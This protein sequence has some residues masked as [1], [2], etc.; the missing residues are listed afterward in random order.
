MVVPKYIGIQVGLEVLWA[1][2][3]VNPVNT[4]L[5]VAPEAINSLGMDCPSHILFGGV[6]D[7]I[8]CV[9]QAGEPVI[10]EHF[11]S[12]NHSARD[13]GDML[14]DDRNQCLGLDIWDHPD[15]SLPAT[16]YYPSNNG[17]ACCSPST[18][19]RPLSTDVGFI[20]FDFSKEGAGVFV[21]QLANLGKDTPS[22]LVGDTQFPL[23]LLCRDS[24]PRG[25]HE[26]DSIEPKA[27]WG[28]G[29]VEYSTRRG[30][31]LLPAVVALVYLT[32][33]DPVELSGL[34]AFDTEDFGWVE[35]IPQPR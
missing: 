21:H 34:L 9:P 11:I 29:L 13:G 6:L 32:G 1:D 23:Q 24:S 25:G 7:C 31:D 8:V 2:S 3:M 12:V 35:M 22:G 4:P 16:F 20:G 26:E 10:A 19:P 28:R 14:L 15:D 5:D 27:E 33:L 17:F 30:R 18:P